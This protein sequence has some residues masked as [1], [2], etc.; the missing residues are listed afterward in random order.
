MIISR[1]GLRCERCR[2][3]LLQRWEKPGDKSYDYGII[4]LP[5]DDGT[6]TFWCVDCYKEVLHDT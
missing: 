1:N 2:R 4:S 5:R 6:D 3:D